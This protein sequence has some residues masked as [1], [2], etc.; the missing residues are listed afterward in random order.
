MNRSRTNIIK[1]VFIVFIIILAVITYITYKKNNPIQKEDTQ[2]VI[3][4]N[5]NIIKE[6]KLGIAEF[7]TINPI[8]T[9]NRNVQ[10][11]TKLIFDSLITFDEN[12]NFNYGLAKEISKKSNREYVIKFRRKIHS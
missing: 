7:D 6:M 3:E 9:K 5:A 11:I 2:A 12:Y 10:S 8:L 1:Y 4:E